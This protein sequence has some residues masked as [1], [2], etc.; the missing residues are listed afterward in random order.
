MRRTI[1]TAIALCFSLHGL[2]FAQDMKNKIESALSSAPASVAQNATVMDLD[3]TV[4]REGTNGW[5]CLPDN[6]DTPGNDPMCLDD[7]WVN[8]LQA[9]ASQEEP[10]YTRMGFGYM[11]AGGSPGSNADP[12]AEG[13][14]PDNEWLEEGT[15]HIM[16][17]VPD[18]TVLE[19]L[20]TYPDGGPWVMWEGT[21]YVHIMIPTPKKDM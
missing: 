21:P 17:I 14:T 15:P 5:T 1:L 18:I 8:W 6:P 10:S 13:P 12:Y 11:L 20:P 7:P 4:I 16:V 19:G 3:M 9:Y 2:A